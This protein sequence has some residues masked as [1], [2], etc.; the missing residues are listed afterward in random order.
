MRGWSRSCEWKE[1]NSFSNRQ[2]LRVW[3]GGESRSASA[4]QT[5]CG[6][7][8]WVKTLN[9]KMWA[10]H[11]KWCTSHWF[12]NPGSAVQRHFIELT[13]RSNFLPHLYTSGQTA[14]FFI[15]V[16]LVGGLVWMMRC[17]FTL[18]GDWRDWD[19]GGWLARGSCAVE[20]FWTKCDAQTNEQSWMPLILNT[21]VSLVQP[22]TDHTLRCRCGVTYDNLVWSVSE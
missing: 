14:V 5:I 1:A 18:K 12:W 17:V 7:G 3:N 19:G 13:E 16:L 9:I 22:A 15:Y 4:A 20:C 10:C 8:W 11:L 6:S 2:A 21:V